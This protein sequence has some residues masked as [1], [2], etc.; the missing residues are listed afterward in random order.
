M[1][2][3]QRQFAESIAQAL[4]EAEQALQPAKIDIG[5]DELTGVTHNR[6]AHISPYVKYGTV[7]AHLGVIRIDT[8]AGEPLA[9]VWNYG[10]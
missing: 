4:V 8:A 1:I 5:S 9:T 2:A 10:T 7:D 3:V 6:R